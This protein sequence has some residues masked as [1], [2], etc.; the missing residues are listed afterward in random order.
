MLINVKEKKIE[1]SRDLYNFYRKPVTRNN[2][3]EKKKTKFS[4]Q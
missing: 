3:R 2:R 4:M 1:D